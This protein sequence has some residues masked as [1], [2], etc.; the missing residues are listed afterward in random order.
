[1]IRNLASDDA[2]LPA[3]LTLIHDAFADVPDSPAATLT[4]AGLADKI[5]Q[6]PA[7]VVEQNGAPVACV[8]ARP[9][10]DVPGALYFG[11]LAVASTARR[12]GLARRLVEAL[13][14]HAKTEGFSG[15][16][17]ETWA[18]H[19]HLIRLYDALGFDLSPGTGETVIMTRLFGS[20]RP[21]RFSQADNPDPLMTLIR[22]SFAYME[23]LIDPPS[24]MTRLTPD[25]IRAHLA[26]G[27]IWIIGPATAPEA[28]V[29][30]TPDTPAL[31][32][33]KL[34]VTSRA[35]NRGLARALVTHAATR[36]RTLGFDRL[37]LQSRIELTENHATFR[38]LGF[39]KTAATA[40]PGYSRATSITFEK[41]L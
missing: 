19:D 41:R 39:T 8:F 27:E 38:H 13:D 24:S 18:G 14:T 37:R 4:P 11:T 29:F 1:V 36:A 23:G 33:G 21:R 26:T 17:L 7:L 40:H 35:R 20:T 22:E 30:L 12:H 2:A 34:A 15:L 25:S 6:G 10:R 5:A 28:C 32:L 16:T 9:S 3:V 31:Y